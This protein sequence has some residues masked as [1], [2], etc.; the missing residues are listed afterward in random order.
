MFASR[1]TRLVRRCLAVAA[2]TV[3]IVFPFTTQSPAATNVL[4]IQA[5]SNR[6]PGGTLENGVLTLHLELRQADWY[7]ESDAGPRMRVYAFAEV[8]SPPQVPGPLIRIPQGTEIR[9]TLRNLLPAVAVVHGMHQHPGEASDV[10]KVPASQVA[11]LRFSAGVPGTYQ[12]WASAGGELNGGR[13]YRE[14]SQLAGAFIVDP[15]GTVSPDRVFVI[16]LWRSQ[17]DVVLSQDVPVINGKSWPYTERLSYAAGEPVRWRWINASDSVH[18]LHLHG[19]YYRVDSEGDGERDKIFDATQQRIVV[20]HGM[21]PGTTMLTSWTPLAGRWIFHC[22]LVAHF[23]PE[24][25]ASNALVAQPQRIHEHGSNH[26]AGLV[27]GITV[28]G[29]RPAVTSH[30]RTR[31]LRLLVRERPARD[32]LPAGFGYQFDESRKSVSQH[33]TAPGPPLVLERGRPVEIT[34]VNQLHEPTA[35]HWHGIEL[36]S[37]YDGVI[38]WGTDGRKITPAIKPGGSFRVRF[39]PPRA[40]TF[41]YH[42]HLNDEVQLGGG[43]YGPLIVLEPGVQFDTANDHIFVVSRGGADE[44]KAPRLLNGSA[45]DPATLYW[46]RGQRNRL[47]LIDITANNPALFSLK[48]PKGLVQWRAVAKDGADLPA[49]QAVMQDSQQS[50][51]SGETY[52][53]EFEPQEPGSLLLEVGSNPTAVRPWKIVQRIEVQ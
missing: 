50:L 9:V 6:T 11:E 39:T 34:I 15:P 29:K 30:G 2:L 43:L 40:G 44:V 33:L 36:E 48:G 22:H 38:G 25:T 47:R 7:P 32:G 1:L 27:L 20:T 14:D 45:N 24:M 31:K 21:R 49:S 13:P 5:N 17:V 53:F 52:D 37:Y 28:T 51:W 18:P 8:G 10:V 19:S 46:H 12:Y 4:T 26:M 35:V 3:L 41:I 16:G 23:L 42:A